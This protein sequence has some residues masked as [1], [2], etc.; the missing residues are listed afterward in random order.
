M[1]GAKPKPKIRFAALMVLAGLLL[2]AYALW[3]IG[4]TPTLLQ[5][6]VQADA[7]TA[8]PAEPG[9][10]PP[11]S[12]LRQRMD[13]LEDA[14]P[15]LEQ[16]VTAR[17]LDGSVSAVQ[18]TAAETG[19]TAGLMA[20]ERDHFLV[21]PALLLLGRFPNP[22]E[23]ELGERVILLDEQ[24]AL[25]LFRMMEAVDREVVLH[26][27]TYRVI[28][29]LRH[30]KRVG[31]IADRYA[32]IPLAAAAKGRY[33]LEILRISAVPVPKGGAKITFAEI[34]EQWKPGG[35]TYDLRREQV[36]A[37]IWARFLA[38]GAGFAALGWLI[39]QYARSIGALR[40][41][42]REKLELQYITRLLP[43]LLFHILLRAIALLAL[44]ALAAA[45]TN[46]LLE[47]IQVFPEYVPDIL[48]EPNS[49]IETF[50]NLRRTESASVVIRT[51]EIVRLLYFGQLCNIAVILSL[52]GG[53]L[54]VRRRR[55]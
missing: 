20:I 55:A 53:C 48:V 47:P 41:R 28:G 13:A 51:P 10:E 45:L 46:L 21:Y 37:T 16:M 26:S 54:M 2:L 15:A 49:I 3:E 4:R 23:F 7:E 42:M 9:G 6:A 29:V 8:A 34:T 36:G 43:Y 31:D 22:D 38:C 5:Y 40:A 27:Q 52:A 17:T 12:L 44:A 19:A 35:M 32:Y 14:V 50:W 25:D 11:P 1:M 18:L 24:L 30:Q 39:G 33:P